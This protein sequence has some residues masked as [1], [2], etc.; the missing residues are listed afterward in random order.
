MEDL[1]DRPD[2]DE[3]SWLRTEATNEPAVTDLLGLQH[4]DG[5][6]IDPPTEWAL[7]RLRLLGAD[8]L[9]AVRSAITRGAEYLLRTQQG[10]GSWV[11]PTAAPD[12]GSGRQ[13]YDM[14]PLQTALPLIGLG[15]AGLASSPEAERGYEWLLDQRLEDGAWPTGHA[16][17]TNG[18]VAGYRRLPHSRWGCRSNTTAAALALS[19]HDT[20]STSDAARTAVDHLLARETRDRSLLGFETARALGTTRVRG[21]F[22]RFARF[23]PA[24]VL[25]L[26][27]AVGIGRSDQRL[28]DLTDWIRAQR[29]QNGLWEYAADLNAS[30]WV[31]YRLI[32][33]LA[34]AETVAS[35]WASRQPRT[36]FVAYSRSPRRF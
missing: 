7:L 33:A 16:G 34:R 35:D 19:F 18:Y 25:E 20:L 21:F 6:W 24:L 1:L 26:A 17:G 11:I 8:S 22:T 32:L 31:S 10:D 27:T 4:D 12:D 2:A 15:A 28:A 30:R 14:V 3:L 23:D 29:G 36:P 5:S 13:A 9:R